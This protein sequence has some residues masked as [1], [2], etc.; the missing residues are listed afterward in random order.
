[1]TNKETREELSRQ[2]KSIERNGFGNLGP[3]LRTALFGGTSE[4]N[5]DEVQVEMLKQNPEMS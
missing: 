3:V 5:W 2:I 1:M 4:I